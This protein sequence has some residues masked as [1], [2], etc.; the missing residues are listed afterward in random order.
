MH[1]ESEISKAT[2]FWPSLSKRVIIPD[3]KIVVDSTAHTLLLEEGESEYRLIAES[4]SRWPDA[5][6]ERLV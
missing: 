4:V 1:A 5:G 3:V 6:L 2:A